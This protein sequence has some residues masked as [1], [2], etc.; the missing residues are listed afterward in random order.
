[1]MKNNM[2][3]A[4][5]DHRYISFDVF[6]TLLLRPFCRPTDVFAYIEKRYG[7]QDF[8][9]KRIRAER[10]AR[11]E[12][13][14]EEVTLQEIYSFMPEFKNIIRVEEEVEKEILRPNPKIMDYY[15][16]ARMSNKVIIITSD[17]YLSEGL[18]KEC[19]YANGFDRIDHYFISSTLRKQKGSGN[20]FRHILDELGIDPKEMMHFGDNPDVDIRPAFALGIEA[21]LVTKVIDD[22]TEKYRYHLKET[23]HDFASSAL[24]M[25]IA[26][27]DIRSYDDY[28]HR[29]GYE[30]GGPL[31]Y[32]FVRWIKKIVAENKDISD[33]LFVA[34]DGFLLKKAFEMMG[35]DVKAHYVYAPRILN[36]VNNIDYEKG[37]SDCLGQ[38]KLLM[39]TYGD[40]IGCDDYESMTE[41]EMMDLIEKNR[42]LLLSLSKKGRGDYRSYLNGLGIG[43]GRLLIVDTITDKFSA[44]K[45]IGGSVDNQC[46]GAYWVVLLD[47]VLNYKTMDYRTYQMTHAHVLFNWY[48]NEMLL[49]SPEPPVI[50]LEDG[51]PL[52]KEKDD[53]EE[54]RERI[55]YSLSKGTKEFCRDLLSI[56][57]NIDIPNESITKFLNDR[58]LNPT[59][60]DF[61]NFEK[62]YFSISPDHSDNEKM[63]PFKQRWYQRQNGTSLFGTE[64]YYN[65]LKMHPKTYVKLKR[66]R[67]LFKQVFQ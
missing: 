13:E 9:K 49:S 60:K 12:S 45:L 20:L 51:Q 2:T 36:I 39:R 48:L 44:Q 21:Q 54:E 27:R 8:R 67:N 4:I 33:V 25:Q 65:R 23:K 14:H 15:R 42:P 56:P 63:M 16:Y 64:Y 38:L 26:K 22:Y 59:D 34:R 32:A 61:E 43:D 50:G 28:W 46:T 6:D 5:D 31:C 52:F 62:M 40:A 66:I 47:A 1:M 17:T 10:R 37:H 30:Y 41:S 11:R 18:V 7:C 35:C 3:A 55:F 29:F 53:M 24:V 58:L 19:L 57:V